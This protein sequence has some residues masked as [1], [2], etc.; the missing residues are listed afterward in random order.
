[1]TGVRTASARTERRHPFRRLVITEARLAWR[2]P[3]G[4]LW[5]VGLPVL[6]LVIFGSIPVFQEPLPGLGGM[7][8][9]DAYVPILMIVVLSMLAFLSM[10]SALASYRELGVLRRI[11]ATPVPPS[12]VLAAQLVVNLAL[13]LLALTLIVVIGMSGFG[14]ALPEHLPGFLVAIAFSAVCLFSL[15]L[16]IAAFARTSGAAAALGNAAFFPLAFFAGL[17]LPQ[18]Q[19]PDLLRGISQAT[20]TGAAAQALNE[21]VAGQFPSLAPLLLL[22]GYSAVFAIVATRW[23]RWE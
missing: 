6:L 19:M 15:G 3:V 4:L 21:T 9:F 23:F 16:V 1:M 7:T 20:P 8:L 14:L 2:Q 12:R 10:P 22:A 17:W 5:G 11:S 18:Q 13:A